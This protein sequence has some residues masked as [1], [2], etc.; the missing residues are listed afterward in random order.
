MRVCRTAL[1]RIVRRVRAAPDRGAYTLELATLTPVLLVL[2]FA[3]V[4]IMFYAHAVNVAQAA[5]RNGVEAARSYDAQEG[6]GPAAARDFLDRMGE[7]MLLAPSVSAATTGERVQITVTGSVPSLIPG[8]SWPVR[9]VAQGP[10][11]RVE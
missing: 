11:E 9:A 8:T 2:L 5:A 10:V 6:D 3:G 4:Q 1:Q 7:D